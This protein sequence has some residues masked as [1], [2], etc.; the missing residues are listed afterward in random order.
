MSDGRLYQ[1]TKK[2]SIQLDMKGLTE[3]ARI[4]EY[5]EPVAIRF[6]SFLNGF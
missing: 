3:S 1:K 6:L 5:E 4:K 2:L